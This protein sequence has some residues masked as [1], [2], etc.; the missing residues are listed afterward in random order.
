MLSVFFIGNVHFGCASVAAASAA[1]VAATVSTVST[2]AT[3]STAAVA[4]MVNGHDT[5]ISF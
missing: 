2:A 4:L 3:A 5:V 1:V